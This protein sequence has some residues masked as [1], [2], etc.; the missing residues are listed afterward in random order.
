MFID[1]ESEISL[2]E[3]RL[4]LNRAEFIVLYGRRRIGKT[5]L[6]LE[7]I[8]RHG[9]IYLLARETSKTE[10]L[11]R[12]TE[13]LAD[14]FEDDLLRT[15]PLQDW[16][17]FFEYLSQKTSSRQIVVLDEFP[18]L[19]KDDR[20]LPS[21]LQEYWDLKLSRTMI[22]LVICGSSVSMMGRLLGYRNPLYGRRTA[23]LELKP[24]DFFSAKLF[25]PHSSVQDFV[26]VYGA[27]GGTPMYLLEFSDGS[28]F[29]E[30]LLNYFR[31][32]SFLYQDALFVLREELD[33]PRNYFAIMEAVA[34]GKT[35]LG[36]IMNETGLGRAI[37]GKYLS[38]LRD[39]GFV[40]R[41]VPITASWK[42]RKARYYVNDPYFAFWFRYVH[43][44]N[45]LIETDQGE[46]LVDKVM[47]DYDQY[48]GGVFEE[49]ARQFLI[50][51]NKDGALPLR[52]SRLGRWW[53]RDQE[54]DLVALDEVGKA[55]L[56]VEVKWGDIQARTAEDL[57][58][59]LRRKSS[60]VGLDGW[61]L[62]Y[63][64]IARKLKRT[65][66]LRDRHWIALQ[67]A[68]FERYIQPSSDRL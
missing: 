60:T 19:V 68:D 40:R 65:A 61:S 29:R 62:F 22:F 24:M 58:R 36:E 48:L 39:L 51:L 49:I 6:L 41:E 64:I 15:N 47:E 14:H 52:F 3:D 23:Q 50:R 18:Y 4:D 38:I 7:L 43:P 26:R 28:G 9:G 37:V 5:T 25:L 54:I 45:D 57:L 32:S 46:I 12:F 17:S 11:R 67:L 31:R 34:R 33:E 21:V 44:N 35:T 10:N 27:V 13:K 16:D 59:T 66:R 63:G 30:N 56:F 20:S 55:A 53:Y 8:R 1:R 42:S 2:L